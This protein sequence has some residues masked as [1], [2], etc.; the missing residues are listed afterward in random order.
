MHTV[1]D[2]RLARVLT[3]PVAR[4]YF[5]PFLGRARSATEAAVEAGCALDVMLYRVRVFLKVGLLR[6]VEV[7]PRKGR[8]IRVYRTAFDAYFIPHA[9]TPFATLEERLYTTAEPH[10]RAWARSVAGR[11]RAR[12][13][14]G[15]RLY[16]DTFGQV[17]SQSAASGAEVGGLDLRHLARADRPPGF[18]VTSTLHLTEPEARLVQAALAELFQAWRSRSAPGEGQPYALSVFFYREP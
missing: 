16:R 15:V 1:T 14:S 12:D 9:L 13:A 7:R 17:F 5:E 11:L 6:V 18:D 8:A 4:P 3:D 2:A 10:L